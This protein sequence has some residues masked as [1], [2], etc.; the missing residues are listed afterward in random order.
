MILNGYLMN[1]FSNFNVVELKKSFKMFF[2][3]VIF[4]W[5]DKNLGKCV[6]MSLVGVFS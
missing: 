5:L 6:I 4:V 3:E 1:F 2:L